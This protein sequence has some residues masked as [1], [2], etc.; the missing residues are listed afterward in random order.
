MKKKKSLRQSIFDHLVADITRGKSNAGEKLLESEIAKKYRVSRTP[1]REAIFQLEKEGYVTHKKDVGAVVKKI[2]TQDIKETFEIIALLESYAAVRVTQPITAEGLSELLS[3][4]KEM[5]KQVREKRY[6]DYI[7]SNV[8]F[9][10]FFSERCGSETL[11]QVIKD[12]RRKVHRLLLVGLTVPKYVDHYLSVHRRIYEAIRQGDAE[13]AGTV[14][15]EH[16]EENKNYILN[17]MHNMYSMGK[18]TAG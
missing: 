11:L 9:H 10:K 15:R 1:V 7:R 14:M 16:I 4:I 5:E 17:E 2:S 6:N 3:Q 18:S 12:L 8:M 13:A